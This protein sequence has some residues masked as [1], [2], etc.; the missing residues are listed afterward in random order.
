MV[1]N[2]GRGNY[3]NGDLESSFSI[4]NVRLTIYVPIA[5]PTL[6]QLAGSLQQSSS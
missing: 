1:S 3:C 6:I 5:V 4:Y 2:I